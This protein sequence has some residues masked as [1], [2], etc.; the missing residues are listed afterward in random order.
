MLWLSTFAVTAGG[1]EP[2]PLWGTLRAVYL[3]DRNQCLGE[4]GRS[5]LLY[6]FVFC[7]NI[8]EVSISLLKSIYLFS[9]I[10]HKWNEVST[11]VPLHSIKK[12]SINTV[13]NMYCAVGNYNHK[14]RTSNTLISRWIIK[15]H[16]SA[17]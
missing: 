1:P 10:R 11:C 5:G 12:Y 15:N 6:V 9:T 8:R 4:K 13:K 14:G 2:I 17:C 7:F 16:N 3:M